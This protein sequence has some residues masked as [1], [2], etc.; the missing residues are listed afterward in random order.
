MAGSPTPSVAD[1]IKCLEHATLKVP[2]EIL[3]KRF[4]GAQKSIDREISHVLQALTDLEQMFHPNDR[5]ENIVSAGQ[6]ASA[7]D[8]AIDRLHALKRKA[9]ASVSEEV[10]AAS[11]VKR[12]VEHLKV[13]EEVRSLYI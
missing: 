9:E 8:S 10:E 5:A 13:C 12:R 6:M 4:R 3:N 1:S 7:V 11:L 2:Y